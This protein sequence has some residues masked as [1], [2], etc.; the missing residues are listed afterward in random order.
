M[1]VQYEHIGLLAGDMFYYRVFANY[2]NIN[3]GSTV[4]SPPTAYGQRVHRDGDTPSGAG[5]A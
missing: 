3:A 2:G 5:D 4:F 1:D